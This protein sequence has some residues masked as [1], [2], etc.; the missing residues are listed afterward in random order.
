[1]TENGF[2][3]AGDLEAAGIAQ[4]ELHSRALA[5]TQSRFGYE[6]FVRAVL[7]VSNT[8]RENCHY[9]GMRRDNRELE[10]YR[11]K[12]ETL[13]D[14]VLNHC[15]SIVTDINLQ[16]GE[17]P[18]AVREVVIPLVKLLRRETA[19]GVSVCVG[20]LS[21][22]LTEEIRAAGAGMYIIKFEMADPSLYKELRAPGTFEERIA[23]IRRLAAEGWNVS[24][25]FIAGL[26]GQDNESFIQNF[27][28]ASQLPLRGCSVSPF[29]PGESTPLANARG[30]KVDLTLNCMAAL[31]LMRP[32]WV[33]PAVSALNIAGGEDGYRRG[34][35]A[36]ANLCTINLTPDAH[37]GKYLLYKK[38]RFV[39]STQRVSE[40]L[41]QEGLV[42][43]SV[44]IADYFEVAQPR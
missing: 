15:P 22:A 20:T 3:H 23:H 26:P 34:L 2:P 12:F 7:E 10:R 44:S 37:R 40:A 31:R 41:E 14:L 43:S 28:L 18:V 42:P 33:V 5:I 1:M 8:C 25:G 4:E 39:M 29:V 27:H 36:G 35:R 6:I 11:V 24:S 13:A 21:P 16:S 19:L 9:C 32:D 30:G 17:D 38:D